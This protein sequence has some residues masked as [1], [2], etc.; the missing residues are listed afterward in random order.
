M[1]SLKVLVHAGLAPGFALAGVETFPVEQAAQAENLLSY[2]LESGE[3][4]LIAL[5]DSLMMEMQPAVLARLE[6]SEKLF[7]VAIP[8]GKVEDSAGARQERIA[9]LIRQ[10][11]GFHITF[12][13]DDEQPE[14]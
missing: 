8:A 5:D 9:A 3:A 11:I 13:H 1:S 2:W 10:A 7:H 12:R 14:T 4:G 6:A